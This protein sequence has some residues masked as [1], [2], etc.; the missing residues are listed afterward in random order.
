MVVATEIGQSAQNPPIAGQNHDGSSN[1]TPH[2]N[3]LESGTNRSALEAVALG[4]V[5]FAGIQLAKPRVSIYIEYIVCSSA[6]QALCI[7]S[8]S[9]GK[10]A[11]FGGRC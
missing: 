4:G 3:D 10:T 11:H 9:L 5:L 2:I 1:D 6:A 8:C 7:T